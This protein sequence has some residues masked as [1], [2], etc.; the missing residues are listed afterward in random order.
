MINSSNLV[1]LDK[2][3]Q[4]MLNIMQPVEESYVLGNYA[5]DVAEN[6]FE[7][8]LENLRVDDILV[9]DFIHKV[10]T[11]KQTFTNGK[12]SKNYVSKLVAHRYKNYSID[13]IW[14]DPPRIRIIPNSLY[15]KSGVSYNYAPHR[16]TWYSGQQDQLNHWISLA[17][18]TSAS[19]MYICPRYF[20]LSVKNNSE[21]YDVD[22]WNLVYRSDAVKNIETDQRP[23][24]LP[25]EEIDDNDKLILALDPL[26]EICFS[27][28]HLHG[29]SYN[30]TNLVRFSIDYRV[31][32]RQNKYCPPV[33]IDNK[34]QGNLKKYMFKLSEFLD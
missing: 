33:N 6:I 1:F 14:I 25:L 17:N 32:I 10:E 19:S 34:S 9:K 27:G 12:K 11:I 13:D 4:G 31:F 20:K 15:L 18:V 28:H 8:A 29:S 5:R 2:I 23:H 22:K 16:D 26:N 3:F 21:I 7:S 30:N 24:P